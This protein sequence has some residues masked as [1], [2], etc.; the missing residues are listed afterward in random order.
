MRYIL[1]RLWLWAGKPWRLMLAAL[2]PK[3][4]LLSILVEH[5]LPLTR[6]RQALERCVE[7]TSRAHFGGD[8]YPSL[9]P[10]RDEACR[11]ARGLIIAP[12]KNL[13]LAAELVYWLSKE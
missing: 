13:N 3:A 7:E 2:L 11:R 8:P 1:R 5:V 4:T 12:H 9:E 10:R 6:D